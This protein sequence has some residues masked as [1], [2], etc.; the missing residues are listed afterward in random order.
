MKYGF[1]MTPYAV[2]LTVVRSL[3]CREAKWMDQGFEEKS[4]SYDDACHNSAV[5]WRLDDWC[6]I[7]IYVE[8][9]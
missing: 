9:T 4:G 6:W 1:A 5:V 2:L 7:Q 3:D 8:L